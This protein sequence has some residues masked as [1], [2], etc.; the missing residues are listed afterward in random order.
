MRRRGLSKPTL[1]QHQIG[2]EAKTKRFTIPVRDEAGRLVNVRR[3]KPVA[4]AS[5][6]MWNLP[7]HGSPPHIFPTMPTG[8]WVMLC[9]GELDALLAIQ[10]GLPAV[11]HTGGVTYWNDAWTTLFKDRKVTITFDCDERGRTESVRRAEALSGVAKAVRVVDLGLGPKE[12]I[13]DWFVTHGRTAEDLRDLI[14][15]TA[16][17]S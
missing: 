12:D 15:G 2:Y 6:K 10:Y 17:W 1:T 4:E 9:E 16:V 7:G 8:R 3:Y 14:V 13:T 5:Q 11:T